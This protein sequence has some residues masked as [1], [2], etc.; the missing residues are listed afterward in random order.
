MYSTLRI[1]L[2]SI[3]IIVITNSVL[4]YIFDFDKVKG[5]FGKKYLLYNIVILDYNAEIPKGS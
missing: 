4:F 1:K 5:G 3:V 2:P